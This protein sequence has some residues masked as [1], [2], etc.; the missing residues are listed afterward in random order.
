MSTYALLLTVAV[1]V[2]LFSI[3]VSICILLNFFDWGKNQTIGIFTSVI[4]LIGSI[5]ILLFYPAL[6]MP[7]LFFGIMTT[8]TSVLHAYRLRQL[9]QNGELSHIYLYPENFFVREEKG[10]DSAEMF[11]PLE[12][13]PYKDAWNS[14]VHVIRQENHFLGTNQ[15][16]L[17]EKD[18]EYDFLCR[19]ANKEGELTYWEILKPAAIKRKKSLQR[20]MARFLAFITAI[21]LCIGYSVLSIAGIMPSGLDMDIYNYLYGVTISLT[22]VVLLFVIRNLAKENKTARIILTVLLVATIISLLYNLLKF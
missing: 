17:L 4:S 18:A 19:C 16:T 12:E 1:F 7:C 6:S 11:A 22:G 13:N 5:S 20:S 8:L 21:T 3:F 14:F 10:R 15:F 2:T 9:K